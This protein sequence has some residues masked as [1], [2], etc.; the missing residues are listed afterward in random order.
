V[1][2]TLTTNGFAGRPSPFSGALSVWLGY[3][4]EYMKAILVELDDRCARD[5]ERVA[6][7]GKGVRAEFIRMAVRRAIDLALERSTELAYRAAP[8]ED[9]L[10]AADLGGWDERN[11]LAKPAVLPKKTLRGPSR[12]KGAA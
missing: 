2:R 8:L 3:I 10:S 5:L 6:P 7:V 9:K 11:E 12:R 4:L 1:A